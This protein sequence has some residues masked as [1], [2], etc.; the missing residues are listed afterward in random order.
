[1]I[2]QKRLPVNVNTLYQPG[3]PEYH[4]L[5]DQTG[6]LCRISTVSKSPLCIII[7]VAATAASV[8]TE[9]VTAKEER[10]RLA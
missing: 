9:M 1:M 3:V 6:K 2:P 4:E 5:E 10:L 8:G 7:L